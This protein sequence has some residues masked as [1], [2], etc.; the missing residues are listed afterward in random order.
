MNE[1]RSQ[2]FNLLDKYFYM[3]EVFAAYILKGLNVT[4]IIFIE[5]YSH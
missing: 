1:N 2:S 4:I 3:C 5:Y